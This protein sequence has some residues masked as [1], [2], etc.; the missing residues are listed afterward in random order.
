MSILDQLLGGGETASVE[1]SSEESMF[2]FGAAPALEFGA[3]DILSFSRSE[4]DN[5]DMEQTSF[6]GI[7]G[8]GLGLGA[9]VMIGSSSSSTNES[10]SQS[11][12]DGLLGGLL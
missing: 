4:D 10:A 1:N 6:T 9:P 12:S 5:G 11:D 8:I 7:G 3:T 2:E